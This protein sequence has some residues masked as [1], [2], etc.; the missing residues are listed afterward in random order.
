MCLR[1]VDGTMAMPDD[2]S[3]TRDWIVCCVPKRSHQSV[4]KIKRNLI[5]RGA[6]DFTPKSTA[7]ETNHIKNPCGHL[8]EIIKSTGGTLRESW[9]IPKVGT[10]CGDTRT[11]VALA[12]VLSLICL[13]AWQSLHGYSHTVTEN[14]VVQKSSQ[15]QARHNL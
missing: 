6:V 8:E 2:H 9:S 11:S 4:A 12:F 7:K 1:A 10:S 14:Y 13:P 3:A 5:Y 15:C